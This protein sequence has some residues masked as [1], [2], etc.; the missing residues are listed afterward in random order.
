MSIASVHPQYS[1][2]FLDWQLMRHVHDGERAVKDAAFTYLPA[3]P[4]QK[5]DGLEKGNKGRAAYDA[6]KLRAVFPG[7]V[8][9]AV[10]SL[11]GIMHHNP[12]TIELP[13]VMEPL[14]EKGTV[15]GESLE[16]LLRRINEQQL[17]AGRIG[18][19]ADL[20]KG[21]QLPCIATYEAET[22]INWDNG[23]VDDPTLQS[24]NLVVLDESEFVRVNYFE[25]QKEIKHR[26]LMLGDP[27]KDEE[28]GVYAQGLF[29]EAQA[30]FD[31]AQMIVPEIRGSKLQQIPFVFIN[32]TDLLPDPLKPPLLELGNLCLAIYRGEADYRQ[33][34]FMQAQD[35]L[36]V[37]GGDDEEEYQVGAGAAI[38]IPSG[39]DAKFVGVNSAG[40]SEQREALVN[41]KARAAQLSGSLIDTTSRAKESGDALRIR[42]AAQTAS[43]PRI[44]M[45]GAEGLQTLLRIIAQWVG[46]NP[47]EVI[48]TPNLDF[49]ETGLTIADLL[50]LTQAKSGGAPISDESLHAILVENDL[51]SLKFEE[52]MAKLAEEKRQAAMTDY[53]QVPPPLSGQQPPTSAIQ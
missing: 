46:A 41:D 51:T 40:L 49:A 9:E 23:Q 47:D 25:W 36:V 42:V 48:V 11:I 26:V 19:L 18:L 50:Q 20:Q 15:F 29:L 31:Q 13:A 6:Y 8:T 12:P 1:L 32:S 22:V 21:A 43:L 38:N 24:L 10:K 14:R 45:A 7:F 53:K 27:L 34:L 17:I 2:V 52:E 39:G 4:G 28:S 33:H 35:T 44:A 30:T 37:I 5:R 3:T 16:L